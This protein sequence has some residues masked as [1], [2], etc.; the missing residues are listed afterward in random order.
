MRTLTMPKPSH[1]KR[2]LLHRWSFGDVHELFPLYMKLAA[3]TIIEGGP[4][5]VPVGTVPDWVWEGDC[6]CLNASLKLFRECHGVCTQV[7]DRDHDTSA[8]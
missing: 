2:I 4:H 1:L 6:P 8:G 7:V 3:S 5:V